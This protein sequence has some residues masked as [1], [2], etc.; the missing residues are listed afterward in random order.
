MRLGLFDKPA[1]TVPDKAALFSAEGLDIA[2]RLATESTVLLKN[3]SRALPLA[4]SIGKVAVIGP[5]ADS[6]VD[7]MGCW[8]RDADPKEV[9]TP[10][11][12]LKET[13]GA[14]RVVYAPG[15]KTSRDMSR[16]GFAAALEAARDA[17]VVLLF[18]GE[19]QSLSGEAHS[20]AFLDLP[21]AQEAL[22][23]E[24]AKAA[25]PM[26]AVILAGRPLT[27]QKVTERA[28][29][30]LFAWHPGTM[31]GPALADLLFGD[32]VPSGKLTA[33]FP[34]TVGQVPVYYNHMNSGRPPVPADLGIRMGMPKDPQRDTS[35]YIDVDYTPEYPFGFGLS[36][37]TFEY[38][39]LRL[40]SPAV[41]MGGTLTVS[42]DVANTGSVEAEEIVQLY[43]RQLV[44]SVT[45][46]VRELKG[47]RRLRIKPGQKQTVEFALRT[48]DLAF[49]NERMQLVTEP[50]AFQVWMAPDSARGLRGEFRVTE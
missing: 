16:A 38:S 50:G 6:P 22:V 25:K 49:Y 48:E 28:G 27:F 14:S 18:L 21:G 44:G 4:K 12:T 9:R 47:F 31:G 34:R 8:V 30:V 24:V 36:Y 10:L 43:T 46:P 13:L 40:S 37:T 19:E 17:D 26:V 39:N 23:E 11:A 33:S 29:A 41:P 32:A 45:R 5:L 2:K 35:K 7:Q 42:A 3:E 1:P 15:L 20:R